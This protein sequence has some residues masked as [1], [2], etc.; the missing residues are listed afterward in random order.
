MQVWKW[1]SF[2]ISGTMIPHM[3]YIMVKKYG[4]K[5]PVAINVIAMT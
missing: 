1:I 3:A 4:E 5:N 2:L